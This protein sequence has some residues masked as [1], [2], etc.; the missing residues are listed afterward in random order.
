MTAKKKATEEA[1]EAQEKTGRTKEGNAKFLSTAAVNAA[2]VIGP[3][4]NDLGEHDLGELI[5]ELRSRF[6]K[7]GNGDLSQCENMLIGQAAALQAIFG[8]LARRAIQQDSL[9]QFDRFLSLALKAQNQ[10]R[11]TLQALAEFKNPPVVFARQ[12]NFAANQQV[13]NAVS[14][15][16]SHARETKNEQSKLLEQTHGERLD[17]GT[18]TTAIGIDTKLAALD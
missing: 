13:N 6:E 4:A 2:V 5:E 11:C 16:A 14:T 8:N 17:T 9:T 7:V 15:P 18:K 3:Y 1:T 10:C 12:A